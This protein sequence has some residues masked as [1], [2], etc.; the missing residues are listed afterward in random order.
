MSPISDLEQLQGI[1]QPTKESLG[2]ATIEFLK[3]R[4]FIEDKHNV[5]SLSEGQFP[6]KMTIQKRGEDTLTRFIYKLE[7]ETLTLAQS[8]K[9]AKSVPDDFAADAELGITVMVYRRVPAGTP[10]PPLPIPSIAKPM[11]QKRPSVDRD[12]KKE[13]DALR[14]QLQLLE[15]KLEQNTSPPNVMPPTE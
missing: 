15:K 12:L 9:S 1:W 5:V 13:I 7:G 14:N 10:I 3:D 6:K 11:D 8:T 4:L 2:G